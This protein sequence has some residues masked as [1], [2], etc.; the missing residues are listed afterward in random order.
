MFTN[1]DHDGNE[2]WSLGAHRPLPMGQTLEDLASLRRQAHASGRAL[3]TEKGRVC[4]K[5]VAITQESNTPHALKEGDKSSLLYR[6][7]K[8][9]TA[10][11]SV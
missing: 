2:D 7:I 3:W 11:N 4:S 5:G 9:V 8:E 10:H 1:L 6:Q